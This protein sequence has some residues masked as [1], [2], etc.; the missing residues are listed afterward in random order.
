MR[1]CFDS[2]DAETGFGDGKRIVDEYLLLFRFLIIYF[3]L[4]GMAEFAQVKLCQYK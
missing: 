3:C 4:E 1:A 2:G